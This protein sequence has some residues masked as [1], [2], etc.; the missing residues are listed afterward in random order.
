MLEEEKK[1]KKKVEPFVNSLVAHRG[2]YA[3]NDS[4]L[5][6]YPE[7][8]LPAFI[9]AVEY[10][11]GIEL[12]VRLTKDDRIVVFHDKTTSRMC[13]VNRKISSRTYSE[14][15]RYSL[16]D[17]EYKIPDFIASNH[18]YADKL[19]HRIMRKLFNYK[20]VRKFR[21]SL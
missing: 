21:E 20:A 11:Y 15:M 3:V 2:L 5:K 9:R 6:D 7:N 8:S 12:D 1:E 13:G 18:K 16:L 17:T 19:K 14:L 10:G 4:E